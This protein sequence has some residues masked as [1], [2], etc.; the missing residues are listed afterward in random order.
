LTNEA[1]HCDIVYFKTKYVVVICYFAS[2]VNC[3]WALE[4]SR[5]IAW[6]LSQLCPVVFERSHFYLLADWCAPFLNRCRCIHAAYFTFGSDLSVI[7]PTSR[8]DGELRVTTIHYTQIRCERKKQAAWR[9]QQ[10]L[11]NGAD[12]SA[13]K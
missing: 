4:Q 5:L 9:Q 10:R 11:R 3:A 12:Q 8:R 1:K 7:K 13:S 2:L 6:L